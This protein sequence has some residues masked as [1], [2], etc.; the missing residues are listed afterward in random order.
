MTN[1]A[2]LDLAS[3]LLLIFMI[4]MLIVI[5]ARIAIPLNADILAPLAA[6]MA[7]GYLFVR[8]NRP[9]NSEN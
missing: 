6:L 2:K 7:A 9:P 5:F 3:W 1:E 8:K 4:A